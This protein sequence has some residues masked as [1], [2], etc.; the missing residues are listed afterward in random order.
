MSLI[1][2]C[3]AVHLS[4]TACNCTALNND[5]ILKLG[6]AIAKYPAKHCTTPEAAK[7]ITDA[8]QRDRQQATNARL[9]KALDAYMNLVNLLHTTGDKVLDLSLINT[10]TMKPET[11]NT[12]NTAF[13]EMGWVLVCG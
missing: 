8:T 13:W 5:L 1:A 12:P 4:A 6:L 11:P 3:S 10:E 2:S 9:Q 7:A